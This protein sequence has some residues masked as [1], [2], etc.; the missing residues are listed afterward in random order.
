MPFSS[1][2]PRAAIF[3]ALLLIIPGLQGC[4]VLGPEVVGLYP[5][6]PTPTPMSRTVTQTVEGITAFVFVRNLDAHRVVLDLTLAGPAQPYSYALEITWIHEPQLPGPVLTAGGKSLPFLPD[7]DMTSIVG[8][9]GGLPLFSQG[10]IAFDASDLHW[11]QPRVPLHLSLPLLVNNEPPVMAP[12]PVPTGTIPATS[13]PTEFPPASHVITFDFTFDASYD[14]RQVV[15]ESHQE[16]ESNGV[17]IT[18]ERI[19][20]TASEARMSVRYSETQAD[21]FLD[22][23]WVSFSKLKVGPLMGPEG[24]ETVFTLVGEPDACYGSA[25]DNHCIFSYDD[26][27]LSLI[28]RAH[29]ECS[30]TVNVGPNEQRHI[31]EGYLTPTDTG[32]TGVF[33][34]TLPPP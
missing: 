16:A 32:V 14:T 29:V 23:N 22:R 31:Q 25:S 8:T 26:R 18:L 20:I 24:Q 3:A 2:T 17:K 4:D 19:D 21:T 34:F 27:T 9:H 5:M 7:A 15:L 33:Q 11:D 13:T 10:M 30:L 28:D 6:P 1:R 12:L